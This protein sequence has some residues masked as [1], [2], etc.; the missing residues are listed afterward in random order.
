MMTGSKQPLHRHTRI[1]AWA[2][3]CTVSTV[4]IV[5]GA[6]LAPAAAAGTC[7]QDVWSAHGNKQNL[8]CTSN[9]V[10]LAKATNIRD[11][12]GNPLSQCQSGSTFSF[13]ADFQVNLGAQARY[14]VGLYF[15][16]DGDSNHNGALGGTCDANIISPKVTVQNIDFGST[17]FVNLDNPGNTNPNGDL[18]GDID[19]AHNPQIITVRID[20]VLC[21]AGANGDLSL[22]NCTSWREPGANQICT[23]P[24]DA[25]PG[26]PSKCNCEPGFTVPI[27]VEAGSISV[28]KQVIDPANA[29]IAEPGGQFTYKV[30]VNNLA[31]VTS[32][33]LHRICDDQ[34]G[35]IYDDGSNVAINGK[36]ACDS[37]LTGSIDSTLCV[38]PQTLAGGGEYDCTFKASYTPGT[39]AALTDT[40]TVYGKDQNNVDTYSSDSAKVTV[41]D[42]APTASV[43]KSLDSLLCST[44]RYQV[45]VN[46]LDDA[47]ALTLSALNDDQFGSITSVH[48]H[49]L[50]TTC[51]V[52]QTIAASGNYTCTFDAGFCG[53]THTNTVTGTLNDSENNTVSP[54]GGVTVNVSAQ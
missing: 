3:I 51:A 7:I 41:S 30:T 52:P 38:L 11:V 5:L 42:V 15:A 32:V 25:F 37:G 40:V 23:T 21:Q 10:R 28:N 34:Y 50:A 26:S 35:T 31:T 48:D 22:P 24:N 43:V 49:V 14:D 9:D 47:E 19:A 29:T 39:A 16:T 1:R 12:S 17:H 27:F 45:K 8:V 33:T 18:C 13:I 4:A 2:T 46:N 54:T 36:T 53:G 20:N 6:Q 44:V